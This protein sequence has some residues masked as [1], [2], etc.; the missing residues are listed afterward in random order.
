MTDKAIDKVT[1]DKNTILQTIRALIQPGD[2]AE[3]RAFGV[4][5][6]DQWKPHVESGYFDDHER[7][8]D[9]AYEL[10]LEHARGV[11][12]TL[13]PVEQQLL[14]RAENVVKVPKK[15]EAT[16]DD[17]ITARRWLPIDIDP[18]RT[19]NTSATEDERKAAWEVMKAVAKYLKGEGW[20]DPIIGDSG[21]GYHL[22]YKIDLPADDRGLVGDVLDALAFRFDTEGAKVDRVNYNA[23]RIWK[24]YGTVNRK[25]DNTPERPH[26][27][28]KLLLGR[29]GGLVTEK[30]MEA[31]GASVPQPPSGRVAAKQ[32]RE[33]EALDLWLA[34]HDLG[35]E[36]P[37]PWKGK[38]RRWKFDICPWDA[39][40][41][42]TSAF[43]VQFNDGGIAAGCHHNGCKGKGWKDLTNEYGPLFEKKKKKAPTL[44]Q[45]TV[46]TGLELTDMG[47][48]QRMIRLHGTTIRY[49]GDKDTWRVWNGVRWEPDIMGLLTEKAKAAIRLIRQE[50][51]AEPDQDA[52]AK[53]VKWA[54]KSQDVSRVRAMVSLARTEP[55]VGVTS[56]VWD[57]APLLLNM[58]NGTLN[59]DTGEL[60]EHRKENL[61]TKVC[62]VKHDPDA[63]SPLWESF[64]REILLDNEELISYVQ[65]A[66]GSMLTADTSDQVLFFFLGTGANGKSTFLNVLQ[67]IMG[68]YGRQAAPELLATKRNGESQHPTGIA[69]LQGARFVV[70]AEIER[71]AYLSEALV[72]QLTGEDLLKARFM[73]QDFFEFRA[74]H[75]IFI[76]ANHKPIIRG[77]D[78]GIWRRIHLIPFDLT[79]PPEDRDRALQGKLL[80]ESSGILNWLVEGCRKWREDGLNPPEIVLEKTQEYRSSMDLLKEFLES[81]CTVAPPQECLAKDLYAAYLEWAA[82]HDE[83]PV[84][85]RLFN[86]MLDE[87]GFGRRRSGKGLHRTGIGLK[88]GLA[89]TFNLRAFH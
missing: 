7:M 59:L 1:A 45:P 11:Y 46:A 29:V 3:L 80:E 83:I 12:L 62:N 81:Y 43:L 19:S 87:R 77:N 5:S 51:A 86:M 76:A 50:A 68:T 75:H 31:I 17:D 74:S 32:K 37:L 9:I 60:H 24:L 28:A 58:E 53:V 82:E 39:A 44:P 70:S 71:G 2:I 48:A 65:R 69:D 49:V 6:K 23:S 22:L 21:N 67:R 18:T 41:T 33:R 88:S 13:N 56:G 25:G 30:Q 15:G 35:V 73:R 36:G 66:C 14:S 57:A 89:T 85:R 10:S 26:R 27:V 40:H 47:N 55:G 8:A 61:I 20:A 63:K 84:K 64:V 52:Q 42:D 16:A 34:R 54:H 78:D 4:R 38:G 72:K 79:V